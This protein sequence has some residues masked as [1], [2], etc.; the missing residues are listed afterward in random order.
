[1]YEN[2]QKNFVSGTCKLIYIYIY[3]FFFFGNFQ[4]FGNEI[5]K[6]FILE[7]LNA[8]VNYLFCIWF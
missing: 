5:Q 7:T 3:M 4:N 6:I 8:Y 2:L 1:M